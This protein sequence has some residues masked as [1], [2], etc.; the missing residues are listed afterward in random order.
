MLESR[1]RFVRTGVGWVLRKLS[2]SDEGRV[3]GFVKANLERFSREALKNATKRFSPE[4]AE[5]LRGVHL[6]SG[7]RSR[8][9]G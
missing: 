2:R 3:A 1:E 7:G 6:P 8:R 9:Q 4:V 5:R